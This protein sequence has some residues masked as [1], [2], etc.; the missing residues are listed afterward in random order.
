MGCQNTKVVAE[1]VQTEN[2]QHIMILRMLLIIQIG[3]SKITPMGNVRKIVMKDHSAESKIALWGTLTSKI[4]SFQIGD[5][6]KLSKTRFSLYQK[7]PQ[8]TSSMHSTI[9]PAPTLNLSTDVSEG[10][11]YDEE[12]GGGSG[13]SVEHIEFFPYMAC[14]LDMCNRKKLA[15]SN[16]ND[17]LH[18]CPNCQ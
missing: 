9:S 12:V 13:C 2:K 17:G 18:Q 7:K 3:E 10:L 1:N 16:Q 15:D 5:T 14:P 4:E 11:R 6:I 8:I